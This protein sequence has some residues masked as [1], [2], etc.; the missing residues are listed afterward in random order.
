MNKIQC[1]KG[2]AMN[3]NEALRTVLVFIIL[4]TVI[5]AIVWTPTYFIPRTNDTICALAVARKERLE[6]LQ[7][8]YLEYKI[9]AYEPAMN[10][11]GNVFDDSKW[12]EE[13][14]EDLED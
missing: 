11:G 12:L 9:E 14:Y 8:R 2:E 6:E 4:M 3:S 1:F 10:C 13:S 5:G 7:I